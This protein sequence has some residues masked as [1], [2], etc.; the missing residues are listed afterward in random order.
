MYWKKASQPDEVSTCP[1]LPCASS[2]PAS[3][4]TARSRNALAA[5]ERE[6]EITEWPSI[7]H[8]SGRDLRWRPASR[9]PCRCGRHPSNT[10]ANTAW[11]VLSGTICCPE[12]QIQCIGPTIKHRQRMSH[13]MSDPIGIPSPSPL[14]SGLCDDLSLL[15]GSRSR[16]VTGGIHAVM[17]LA[18]LRLSKREVHGRVF[19]FTTTC[20][21]S[22]RRR[23]TTKK[24]ELQ[25]TLRTLSGPAP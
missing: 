21:R 10:S 25:G 18:G 24:A 17:G 23:A 7:H 3:G 22:N 15:L 13:N 16:C 19:R 5:A 14:V 8:S 6:N 20:S 2:P 9:L 4:H 12:H 11:N 1:S